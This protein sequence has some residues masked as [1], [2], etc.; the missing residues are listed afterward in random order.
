MSSAIEVVVNAASYT[1]CPRKCKKSVT[2]YLGRSSQIWRGNRHWETMSFTA[3][4]TV[5]SSSPVWLWEILCR[6]FV[7]L[8]SKNISCG[9]IDSNQIAS[10]F[11]FL[12]GPMVANRQDFLGF[13]NDMDDEVQF[14]PPVS[15]LSSCR[16]SVRNLLLPICYSV[17]LSYILHRAVVCTECECMHSWGKRV[18]LPG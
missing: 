9:N 11:C 4:V 18:I 7:L 6:V 3:H 1:Q 17:F 10:S 16:A 13:K 15:H 12:F 8:G 5:D 14:H 2:V